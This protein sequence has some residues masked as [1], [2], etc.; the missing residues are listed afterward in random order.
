MG[1]THLEQCLY[2][3][4]VLLSHNMIKLDGSAKARGRMIKI[5]GLQLLQFCYFELITFIFVVFNHSRECRLDDR[6]SF[7]QRLLLFGYSVFVCYRLSDIVN[8]FSTFCYVNNLRLLFVKEPNAN[9]NPY[10]FTSRSYLNYSN[11][12]F[13][14]VCS[15][16]QAL[17]R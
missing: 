9:V 13:M 14:Q 16:S 2:R 3:P 4:N 15:D 6:D 8:V 1:L 17:K 12:I 5:D 11:L 7:R 10:C